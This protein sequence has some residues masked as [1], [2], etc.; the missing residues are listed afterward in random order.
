MEHAQPTHTLYVR[1]VLAQRVWTMTM[2]AVRYHSIHAR[3][4]KRQTSVR[5]RK[6]RQQRA[7]ASCP[8]CADQPTSY[9]IARPH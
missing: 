6:A 1:R 7:I 2:P 3:K 5:L 8:T 9:A 4:R